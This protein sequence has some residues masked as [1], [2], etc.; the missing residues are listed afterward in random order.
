M[1]LPLPDLVPQYIV[2]KSGKKTSVVI[3]IARF[4]HF[5]DE[6]ED[7]YLALLAKKTLEEDDEYVSH[8]DVRRMSGDKE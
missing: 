5:L 7:M 3:D 6:V 1:K 8:E 4:E 2:D